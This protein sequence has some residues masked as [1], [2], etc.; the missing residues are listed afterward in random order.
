MGCDIHAYLEYKKPNRFEKEEYWWCF[1]DLCFTRNYRLFALAA[2]VRMHDW[3]AQMHE[4]AECYKKHGVPKDADDAYVNGLPEDKRKEFLD[5][6]KLCTGDTG[7]TMGQEPFKPKGIPEHL[8]H[9]VEYEYTLYVSDDD[10]ESDHFCSRKDAE[11]WVEG[12]SSKWYGDD[13]DLVTHPDWHTPSWLSTDEVEQL[14]HRM[15]EAQRACIPKA[16]EDQK[17]MLEIAEEHSSDPKVVERWKN[18][19]F[20]DPMQDDV[21]LELRGVLGMMKNIE[22]SGGVARMVFWFDN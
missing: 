10:A 15:E 20:F 17:K 8:S 3:F 12:E 9:H 19:G 13:K 7:I 18:W 4:I 5:D 22:E 16:K 2:M 11:G 6:L 21:L 1:S 14:L